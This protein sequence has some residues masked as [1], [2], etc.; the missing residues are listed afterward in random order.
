MNKWPEQSHKTTIDAKSDPAGLDQRFT[1]DLAAE[2]RI[3]FGGDLRYD[4]ELKADRD[5]RAD[6]GQ[7]EC[8]RM[9]AG[10][11]TAVIDQSQHP[12]QHRGWLAIA[13]AIVL[14]IIVVGAL[15]PSGPREAPTQ[16]TKEDWAQLT[17][18]FETLNVQGQQIAQ[19]TQQQVRP[20]LSLP[21]FE[22]PALQSQTEPLPYLDS[23]RRWL[24]PSTP[25]AR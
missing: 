25:K 8:P 22:L 5:F 2:N 4:P 3:Q 16:I 6:L 15:Y 20:H 17:L 24:Q 23:F 10:L 14:S 11:R 7:I 9:T 19:A 12:A 1:A 18:A 13:A 21:E